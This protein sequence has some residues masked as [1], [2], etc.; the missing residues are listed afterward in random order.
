MSELVLSACHSQQNTHSSYVCFFKG[1][2]G[3]SKHAIC[4]SPYFDLIDFFFIKTYLFIA[5]YHVTCVAC[6]HDQYNG[7][8]LDEI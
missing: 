4:R 5:D 3:N 1:Q 2:K 7:A 8:K 6:L